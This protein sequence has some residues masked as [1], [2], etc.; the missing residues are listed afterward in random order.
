MFP[1]DDEDGEHTRDLSGVALFRLYDMALGQ[2]LRYLVGITSCL[3][4]FLRVTGGTGF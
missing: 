4:G 3:K 2:K 1:C